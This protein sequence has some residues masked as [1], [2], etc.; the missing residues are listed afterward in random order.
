MEIINIQSLKTP[1]NQLLVADALEAS[2][3]SL[4]C[5]SLGSFVQKNLTLLFNTPKICKYHSME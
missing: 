2:A 1:G 4:N 3:K 5:T